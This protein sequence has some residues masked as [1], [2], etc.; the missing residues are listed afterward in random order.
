MKNTISRFLYTLPTALAFTACSAPS[1]RVYDGK[2]PQI[3]VR[4]FYSAPVHG[5]GIFQSPGGEVKGRYYATLVP[6]WRG[7]EGTI[8]EKQWNDKGELFFQQQWHVKLEGDGSHFTATATK[9]AGQVIGES[10]GYALHMQY[11]ALVP[12]DNGGET[13]VTSDDWTY[14]QPDG[15]G[16]NKV[17]MS[18]LGFHVGDVTYVLR[19]LAKGEKLHEGYFP[20]T[21]K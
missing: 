7:D 8:I 6:T 20:P 2:S 16:L 11:V 21:K 18:K 4:D 17:S 12:R 15:S 9:I 5:Y 10:S 13:S 3:T 19:K 14:L 1:V